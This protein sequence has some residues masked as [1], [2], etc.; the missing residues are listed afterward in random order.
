MA[1]SY[2]SYNATVEQL[3]TTPRGVPT[4]SVVPIH[5]QPEKNRLLLVDDEHNVLKALARML[6]NEGYDIIT[7]SSG[8]EALQILETHPMD[9][10]ISDQRMPHMTGTELLAKVHQR[11]P[12]TVRMVLSGYAD[13]DSILGAINYG[14]IYKFQ[15]KPWD[16]TQLKAVISECF[17]HH[18]YLQERK[19]LAKALQE[20]NKSLMNNTQ[21]LFQFM[22]SRLQR[23]DMCQDVFQD[24]PLPIMGIDAN[25]RLFL[26][27][28]MTHLLFPSLESAGVME[29]IQDCLPSALL[30]AYEK[31]LHNPPLE[32]MALSVNG[33][34]LRIHSYRLCA[35][36]SHLLLL[37][38]VS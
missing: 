17:T 35:N 27:S 18:S 1:A 6:R 9:V 32:P 5:P 34:D 11:Y 12:D 7:A 26:L 24:F 4:A 22:V 21:H 8:E 2:P 15:T 31:I 13:I 10:V 29:H 37:E 36:N 38:I 23:T 30:E 25:Q 20:E 28:E 16:E 19:V 14:H 33:M 3:F